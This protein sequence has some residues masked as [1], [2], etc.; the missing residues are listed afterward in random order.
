MTNVLLLGCGGNAG[1]NFTK[2][3][4]KAAQYNVI[5]LDTDPYKLSQSNADIKLLTP[6]S[7]KEK[8]EFVLRQI[9]LHDIQAIHAQPDQEVT[10]LLENSS[11]FVDLIFHHDLEKK[12]LFDNKLL[13]AKNW[14]FYLKLNF[15]NASLNE[16]IAEPELFRKICNKAGKAWIRAIKGAGSRG[17][18]PINT[19]DQAINW[20]DYWAAFKGVPRQDFMISEFLP[21]KEYAVQLFYVEG[22]EIH[23]QMRERLVPFFQ[24]QMPS[25][26]S[27]TPAVARTI[28]NK[29]V[30]SQALRAVKQFDHMPHGIYSVDLKESIQEEIVPIEVNYGRFFTTS[31]FFAALGVNTPVAYIDYIIN[32]KIDYQIKS[33][34]EEWYWLRGL[35]Q[36]PVLKGREE[37]ECLRLSSSVS[38]TPRS[39]PA[40]LKDS[41][42]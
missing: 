19:L 26:Q 13:T 15:E 34:K 35:D 30:Y 2:C 32:K 25:G 28:Y 8:L 6:K 16:C 33:I 22:R 18:L 17:A 36:E 5:G 20:A 14:N 41:T 3:L 1:L 38:I 37:I 9:Y 23:S 12:Q 24:N 7:K 10:W 29:E 39:Y 4:K 42:L 27:S 21:G 11:Q 40:P 31:D